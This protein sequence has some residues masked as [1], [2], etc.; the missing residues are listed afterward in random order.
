MNQRLQRLRETLK[1]EWGELAEH[2]GM[3]RAMLDFVR[4]GQRN[5]SFPALRR[6]EQAEREAG[7]SD[8]SDRTDNAAAFMSKDSSTALKKDHISN[9]ST[10][11][12]LQ[13]GVHLIPIFGMAQALGCRIHHGDIVPDN[14][15]ELP[16]VPVL[17]DGRTY[18]AFKV[19]G[20][21]MA[22]SS[23][24]G[25]IVLCDVKRDPTNK[26][27]VVAKWNDTVAI[28]RYRRVGNKVLLTSDN[29]NAGEDYELHAKDIAWCLRVV[30]AMVE[31]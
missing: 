4:K 2:L 25:V 3:S 17:D 1:L 22:P 21:S 13:A 30:R 15:H 31:M 29:P 14:V 16:T 9:P 20:D 18:A 26:C 27:V 19:E 28:K 11:R 12:P 6:L 23:V 8:D 24:A 10:A 7:F 5:L